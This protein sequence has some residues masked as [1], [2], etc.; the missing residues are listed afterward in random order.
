MGYLR[1]DPE[2][3]HEMAERYGASVLKFFSHQFS[4]TQEQLKMQESVVISIEQGYLNAQ[5]NLGSRLL[6]T[7]YFTTIDCTY[8]NF[9]EAIAYIRQLA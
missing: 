3:L 2:Q 8:S 5:E 6:S 1:V 9:I 7:A 4:K